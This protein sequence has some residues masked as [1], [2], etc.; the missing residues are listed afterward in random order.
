MMVP[1][2]KAV[3]DKGG[4]FLLGGL[5]EDNATNIPPPTRVLS[6]VL[7]N[8]NAVIFDEELTGPEIERWLYI[9]QT[10]RFVTYTAQL[11][12]SSLSLAWL[13]AASLKADKCQT[14]VTR[15]AP[16]Q[17]QLSRI[18]AMGVSSVELHLLT[19]WLESPR[20]PCSLHS[21]AVPGPKLVGSHS[22]ESH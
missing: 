15:T 3:R 5:A 8:S 14:V 4:E 7:A 2:L 12:A 6:E 1:F 19:D 18:S 22:E 10:I 11:P 20:F 17:L 13:K 9:G 21:L 16:D